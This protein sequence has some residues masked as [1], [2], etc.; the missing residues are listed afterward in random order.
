MVLHDHISIILIALSCRRPLLCKTPT[1]ALTLK[2]TAV[3]SLHWPGFWRKGLNTDLNIWLFSWAFKLM[4]CRN[5]LTIISCQHSQT[6]GNFLM[7]FLTYYFYTRLYKYTELQFCCRW[8]H[9]YSIIP[10]T[11]YMTYM[12][13]NFL[14]LTWVTLCSLT[15]VLEQLLL[16][17]SI[18]WYAELVECNL[19]GMAYVRKSVCPLKYGVACLYHY[20]M[21]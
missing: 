21:S 9:F 3:C 1:Y 10:R 14:R 4:R 16:N 8:V 6:L 20:C 11:L 12:C 2:S 17:C 19:N 18:S 5:V 15:V 13:F 7:V